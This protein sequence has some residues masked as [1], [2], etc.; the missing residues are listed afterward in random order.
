MAKKSTHEKVQILVR[1]GGSGVTARRKREIAVQ[2][3]VGEYRDGEN[4]TALASKFTVDRL[5]LAR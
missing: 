4:V 1:I 2:K 5:T 3:A